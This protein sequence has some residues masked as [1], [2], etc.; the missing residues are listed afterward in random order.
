MD[1]STKAKEEITKILA[2]E[3]GEHIEVGGVVTSN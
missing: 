1:F 2:K 3:I